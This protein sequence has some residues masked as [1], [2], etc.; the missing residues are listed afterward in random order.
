MKKTPGILLAGLLL[1]LLAACQGGAGAPA[2]Q[3]G[4]KVIAIETFLQDIVQ[5]VAGSRVRVDA[6]I[7]LGVDPHAFEPAPQDVARLAEAQL[8]VAN[9]AGFE[10]WLQKTLTNTGGQAALIEAAAGLKSRSAREGELAEMSDADLV[11]GM[12]AA[13]QEPLQPAAAGADG[14]AGASLGAEAGLFGVTLSRLA[15]GSYGGAFNYLTDES[16]DFQLALSQGSLAVMDGTG[17]LSPRKTM[18]LGCAR[19][20]LDAFPELAA[21]QIVRLE[22]D[23]PY[24]LALSGVSTPQATLLVG[25]AG[26]LHNHV[27]DP[28]FWLDPTQVVHY[29]ETIRDGLS[30][31]DPGGKG[32]YAANAAAYIT[33]LNELDGWIQ[34]QVAGL[35]PARR[36]MV[37]NHESFGYFADRY[38]FRVVGT[39]VPSVSTD[40]SP[41][42]QQL[43]RLVD[44]I[45]A[46]G[47]PAVF[48]E[49]GANPQLAD[50]LARET[51]VKVVTGLYTHSITPAGGLAPSYLEMMRF[52][53]T[54]IVAALK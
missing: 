34:V 47:A 25:P 1:G 38:G 43:A 22:K 13:G 21:A 32:E 9:G 31:A 36:L 50:Q 54:T 40:A 7:P 33:R 42:A 44:R 16:G 12:C 10:T 15:D 49:T 53:V 24:R 20:T 18:P 23:T 5:Q 29:V 48:L 30:Q 6:L 17:R 19:R 37:T 3:T 51:G 52:N 27:G 14:S 45:R 28:H 2:A 35:D 46:T 26:G 39:I 41:S 11:D 8:I 4:L